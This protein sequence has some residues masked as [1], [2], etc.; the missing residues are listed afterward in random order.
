M[1]AYD[2]DFDFIESIMEALVGDR[3]DICDAELSETSLVGIVALRI[4]QNLS[5][6]QQLRMISVSASIPQHVLSPPQD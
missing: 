6:L 1:R 2:V 4:P 5:C 3:H